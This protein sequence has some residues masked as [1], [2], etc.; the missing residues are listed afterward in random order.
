M[1]GIRP[2]PESM[3]KYFAYSQIGLE[4]VV[5][6]VL[7]LLADNNFGWSPWG[8]VVGAILGLVGGLAHLIHLTRKQ[9]EP[10]SSS[11]QDKQ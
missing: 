6:I 3:K 8:V 11:K 9:S 1:L 4:M 5:P 7:G 2:D 10:S